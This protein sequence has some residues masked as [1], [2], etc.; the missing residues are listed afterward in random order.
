MNT[1]RVLRWILILEKYGPEI[2]YSQCKKNIAEYPL[3]QLPNYGNKNNTNKSNYI[4]EI[5]SEVYYIVSILILLCV[6]IK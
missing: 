4:M 3:L 6:R 2:D 1:N 5:I